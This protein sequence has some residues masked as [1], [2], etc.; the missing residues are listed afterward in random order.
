LSCEN[1]LRSEVN[2]SDFDDLLER[3]SANANLHGIDAVGQLLGSNLLFG[4]EYL[5]DFNINEWQE[6]WENTK[7]YPSV[8]FSVPRTIAFVKER[9]DIVLDYPY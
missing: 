8:P 1:E 4:Y 6:D 7:K 2:Q 3:I 5:S 9:F